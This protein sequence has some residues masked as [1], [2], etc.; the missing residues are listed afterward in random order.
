MQNKEFQKIAELATGETVRLM[1]DEGDAV[2]RYDVAWRDAFDERGPLEISTLP[3]GDL[4][5][6][7]PGEAGFMMGRLDDL[8]REEVSFKVVIHILDED[9]FVGEMDSNDLTGVTCEKMTKHMLVTPKNPQN[10]GIEDLRISSLSIEGT[11]LAFTVSARITNAK[12]LTKEARQ[13]YE[14]CWG[15]REWLPSGKE[16]LLAEYA[17]ASN[18]NPSPADMGFEFEELPGPLFRMKTGTI[19]EVSP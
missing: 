2:C 11:K 13:Q 4:I 6:G 17:L 16:E 10:V 18:A 3:A 19:Y 7:W 15:D 14:D 12:C 1:P 8:I 9:L 5:V